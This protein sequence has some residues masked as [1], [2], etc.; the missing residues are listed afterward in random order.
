MCVLCKCF[1]VWNIVI[2][3]CVCVVYNNNNQI[4]SLV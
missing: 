2:V 1:D 4:Q 3:M